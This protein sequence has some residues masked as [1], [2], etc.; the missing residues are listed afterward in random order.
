MDIL[1][2]G[3]RKKIATKG[4]KLAWRNIMHEVAFETS[5]ADGRLL[6][7]LRDWE[8]GDCEQ[9]RPRRLI[10]KISNRNNPLF[11]AR[12]AGMIDDREEVS[13]CSR[14]RWIWGIYC[15]IN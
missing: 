12:R 6:L 2:A 4:G 3:G 11:V 14:R 5:R 7:S 9:T 8:S 13:G 15:T 10:A 1:Q